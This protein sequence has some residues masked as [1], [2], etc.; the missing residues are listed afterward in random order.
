VVSERSVVLFGFR[1]PVIELHSFNSFS[2]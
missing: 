2:G 1:G